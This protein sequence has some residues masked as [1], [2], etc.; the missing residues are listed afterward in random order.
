LKP[1]F[2]TFTIE[3]GLKKLILWGEY[4]H[5]IIRKA[6]L[7]DV[8]IITEIYNDI[9]LN[10]TAVYAY[11]PFT[12]ENRQA[13]F[14]DK[15]A[16]NFPV[17]VAEEDGQVIGFSTYGSFRAAPAYLHSVENTIHIHLD[18]TGRGVGKLLMPPIIEAAKA[19]KMHTMLAGIEA[20]NTGSIKFHQGFGFEQVALFKSVGYK[21]NRWLDLVF[22]QLMLDGEE[23][24][25]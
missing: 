25:H 20:T 19:Q 12:L 24:E 14:E 15:M 11:E 2:N 23:R 1:L 8:P 6:E 4:V 18:Y 16:H 22:M 13:W 7:K 17:F 5:P 3:Q 10:T 9:V 21:F